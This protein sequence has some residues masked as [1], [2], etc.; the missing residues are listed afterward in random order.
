MNFNS[1]IFFVLYLS[2]F[3]IQN[4]LQEIMLVDLNNNNTLSLIEMIKAIAAKNYGK[5]PINILTITNQTYQIVDKSKVET[6]DKSLSTVDFFQTQLATTTIS[7]LKFI[8]QTATSI[9]RIE[10]LK[11]TTLKLVTL[12]PLKM[13]Q[14][15]TLELKICN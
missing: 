13:L 11:T 3:S 4:P 12:E 9:Y 5:M 1:I 15:T 10:P 6:T 7:L 2:K 8:D 14:T